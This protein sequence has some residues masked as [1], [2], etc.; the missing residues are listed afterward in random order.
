MPRAP[1]THPANLPLPPDIVH[2]DRSETYAVML[3]QFGPFMGLDDTAEAIGVVPRDL[4]R[5]V[6]RITGAGDQPEPLPS[7][8]D[9]WARRLAYRHARLGCKTVF[10]TLAVAQVVQ[11]IHRN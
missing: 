7:S 4:L 10:R 9:W 1:W 11:E 2:E 6:N 3:R 8:V 5:Q